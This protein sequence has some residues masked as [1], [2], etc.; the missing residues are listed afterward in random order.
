MK[1]KYIVGDATLP[2][3]NKPAHIIHICNDLGYWGR[4]FVLAISSRWESPRREYIHWFKNDFSTTKF[5]LG[6]IQAV[7]VDSNTTVVNMIAQEGV[8][9]RSSPP[10]RYNHLEECLIKVVNLKPQS[11]HLPRI[12]CG[13]AGGNWSK[14]EPLLEKTLISANIPTFIYDLA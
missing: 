4:G 1:I 12:G 3:S 8:F 9:H 5:A 11:V 2:P 14:I 13:L 10:I 6:E 7:D